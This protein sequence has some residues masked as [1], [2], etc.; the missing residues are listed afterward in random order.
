[1]LKNYPTAIQMGILSEPYTSP[2]AA[3]F[4]AVTLENGGTMYPNLMFYAV[5]YNFLSK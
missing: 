3:S 2:E 1:M 4:E 5:L